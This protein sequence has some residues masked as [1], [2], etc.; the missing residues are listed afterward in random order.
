MLVDENDVLGSWSGTQYQPIA[1][2]GGGGGGASAFSDLTD[3]ATANI[4]VVNGP[5]G[6]AISAAAATATWPGITGDITANAALTAR[7]QALMVGLVGKDFGNYTGSANF[8][9]SAAAQ[10]I[11]T[12]VFDAADMNSTNRRLRIHFDLR[13]AATGTIN[14]FLRFRNGSTAGAIM[15]EA[16]LSNTG[17]SCR[18]GL[19][20]VY[21]ETAGASGVLRQ[22]YTVSMDTSSPA[23]QV[24]GVDLTQAMTW[25]VCLEA[26]ATGN[27]TLI[28]GQCHVYLE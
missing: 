6:A 1:P 21:V 11:G 7:I 24:T 5:T 9:A 20:E 4:P 8:T 26:S 23:V 14:T 15:F 16:V 28:C 18:N 13:K 22:T 3:K 2:D 25:Y 17:V 19:G 12:I 10:Q 27:E